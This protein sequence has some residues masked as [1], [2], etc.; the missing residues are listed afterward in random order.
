MVDE[1]ETFPAAPGRAPD[2]ADDFRGPRLREDLWVDHYLPHWTTP[3]RSRARYDL[4]GA[5]IRL[6]IDEDQPDWRPED[7][8]LRVSNLQTGVFSG[9]PGSGRGTH[10]HRPDGLVVRTGTPERLLWAPSSGRVDVTVSASADD[11]CMLAAWL[12]GTEH[13]SPEHSGEICVFEIDASAVGRVESRARCGLKAHGDPAL[14]TEMVEVTVPLDASLPHT[15]S[16]QW[17]PAGTVIGCEGVVV[18]R[19]AAAPE[20][21]LFLMLDL[22]EI[23]PRSEGPGC[24]PKSARIHAVHGW[25][26]GSV[27]GR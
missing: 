16:V 8:P 15:W 7:A 23:G 10:R 18:A 26:G 3:E 19:S 1:A 17:G 14:V 5:G 2:V 6:R 24:Y 27:R 25:A 21:P 20:Y 13:L 12:V 11:G 9:P 22:F 4:D